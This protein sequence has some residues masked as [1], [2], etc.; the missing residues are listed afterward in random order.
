MFSNDLSKSFKSLV[1]DDERKHVLTRIKQ[2]KNGPVVKESDNHVLFATFSEIGTSNKHR[3][4]LNMYN[5]NNRECQQKFKEYTSQSKMLSSVFDADDDIDILTNRFIK[6][7][8]GCI[9]IC[10]RKVRIN[11]FKESEQEKLLKRMGELKSNNSEEAKR[12]LEN[13]IEKIAL[14]AQLK[15]NTVMKELKEMR[16]EEGKINTQKF[17]KIKKKIQANIQIP[18]QQCLMINKIFSHQNKP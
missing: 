2:T 13:I 18:L 16:P 5:L 6:K 14:C 7:L 12:E 10:F 17:W 15:Y 3:E 11:N 4:K 1:I 8:N 9:A